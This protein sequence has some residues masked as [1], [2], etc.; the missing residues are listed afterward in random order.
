[1]SLVFVW[2]AV[3]C[4]G[5]VIQT[6]L[7]PHGRCPLFISMDQWQWLSTMEYL[8]PGSFSVVRW[9]ARFRSRSAPSSG[10]GQ[11]CIWSGGA[12]L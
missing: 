10:S 12:D 3:A 1:M 7:V 4:S 2:P 5:L 8:K 11:V 6:C 9:D